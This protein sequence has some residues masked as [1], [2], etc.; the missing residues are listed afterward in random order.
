MKN[1]PSA[2]AI[3]NTESNSPEINVEKCK[4]HVSSVHEPCGW[5]RVY[6]EEV[7]RPKRLT[8]VTALPG[9]GQ[10]WTGGAF[11]FKPRY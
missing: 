10:K 3:G 9:L 5:D 6:N 11:L 7:A 4:T 8:A 2:A 1:G